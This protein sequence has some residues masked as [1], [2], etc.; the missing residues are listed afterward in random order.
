MLG[1]FVA[2]DSKLR[3]GSLNHA[4]SD[5]I[6]PTKIPRGRCQYHDFTSAFGDTADMAGPAAGLVAVEN[7]PT[8]T[9]AAKFAVMHNA[10]FPRTVW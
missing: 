7:D 1:E 10:A 6:Q 4:P 2:H 5:T 8:E 3:F 9:L